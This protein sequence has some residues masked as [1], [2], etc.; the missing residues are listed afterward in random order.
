MGIHLKAVAA[1]V[2]PGLLFA[3]GACA[4]TGPSV[5]DAER[6][7]GPRLVFTQ[8][9]H[10]FGRRERHRTLTHTVTLLN[11]GRAP[12]TISRIDTNCGC[13]A[14]LLS[15]RVISPG[16]HGTIRVTWRTGGVAGRVTKALA[17]TTNDPVNPVS[18]YPMSIEVIG[19]AMLDP[20][21]VAF[22]GTR[23]E[24]TPEAWF[25]VIALDAGKRLEI[26]DVQTSHEGI[27]AEVGPLPE[28]D[29]RTGYRVHL[30]FG[31]ELGTGGFHERVIVATNSRRDPRLA[32]DVV[33]AVTRE[34]VVVPDRLYFPRVAGTV[35]R[36]VFVSRRDGKSLTVR[37]VSD[38]TGLLAYEIVRIGAGK[39][40]VRVRLSGE[41][42]A[43][44]AR[45][46]LLIRTDAREDSTVAVP[47]TIAGVGE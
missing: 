12:L 40:E 32:I 21:I 8:E 29:R 14:A 10:D 2:L 6:T 4:A 20:A 30:S 45:G 37:S 13:A 23:A 24:G 34:V 3:A 43:S 25:D 31:A 33:G 15:S 17:V 27:R 16:G 47:V 36:S 42:P 46:S 22:R 11:G 39:V 7:D 38:A 35:T 44:G 41:N 9:G 28:G 18:R 26:I 5:P 1:L 19:D